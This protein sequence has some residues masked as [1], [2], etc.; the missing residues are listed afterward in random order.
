MREKNLGFYLCLLGQN[1]S[2]CCMM[3]ET[4]TVNFMNKESKE[5]RLILVS[6]HIEIKIWQK[7][8]NET[9]TISNKE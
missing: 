4:S 5:L 9:S 3:V 2:F 8:K 1:W 7:K 6:E